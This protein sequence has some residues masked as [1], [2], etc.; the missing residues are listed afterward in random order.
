MSRVISNKIVKTRKEH[1]CWGCARSFPKNSNLEAVTA[2]DEGK[3]YTNYWCEVCRVYWTEHMLY[4][5]EINLGDLK[6]NDPEEWNRI[7][8]LNRFN[9]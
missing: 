8:N 4:D 6:A 5:D 9:S 2:E 1:K 7:A 3:I